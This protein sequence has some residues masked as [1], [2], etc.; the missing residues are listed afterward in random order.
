MG[1]LGWA[2][3]CIAWVGSLA[4]APGLLAAPIKD[5]G[6]VLIRVEGHEETF[7]ILSAPQHVVLDYTLAVTERGEGVLSL[8]QRRPSYSGESPDDPPRASVMRFRLAALELARLQQ[9]IDAA[10]IGQQPDCHSAVQFF[11]YA[12]ASQPPRQRLI[13]FGKSRRHEVTLWQGSECGPE[14]TALLQDLRNLAQGSY[15]LPTER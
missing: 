10:R 8:F 1:K 4:V 7:G 5:Q 15:A 9:R 3:G 14:V 6:R 2:L 13:W 11:A 12:S